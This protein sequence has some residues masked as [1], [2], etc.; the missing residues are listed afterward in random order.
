MANE[1]TPATDEPVEAAAAED[2]HPLSD[3]DDE[4]NA[5][6]FDE[7]LTRLEAAEAKAADHWEQVLRGH[8][9]LENLRKRHSREVEIARNYGA[10]RFAEELLPIHDSLE[11]GFAA[12]QDDGADL[13]KIRE[14]YALTLQQMGTAMDK[15]GIAEIN[16]VGE[17]FDPERHQAMAT[18]PAEGVPANT[19]VKVYQKGW[20]LKERL[21]RPAMVVVSTNS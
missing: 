10:Q 2:Q 13:D 5:L 18:E 14:G 16:P 8:A 21:L 19:V 9:E 3:L 6:S 11:L 17:P 7:A 20:M 12:A 15:L 4:P 1:T